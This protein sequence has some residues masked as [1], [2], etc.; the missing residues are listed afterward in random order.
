MLLCTLNLLAQNNCDCDDAKKSIEIYKKRYDITVKEDNVYLAIKLCNGG[1]GSVFASANYCNVELSFPNRQACNNWITQ[2]AGKYNGQNAGALTGSYCFQC[3]EC[4]NFGSSSSSSM[5]TSSSNNNSISSYNN[6]STS[7]SGGTLLETIGGNLYETITTLADAISLIGQEKQREQIEKRRNKIEKEIDEE[8]AHKEIEKQNKIEAKNLK[9]SSIYLTKSNRDGY[10]L[11][12]EIGLD[13]KPNPLNFEDY[14]T[15]ALW[16]K[17]F[18]DMSDEEFN[19]FIREY[20][21]FWKDYC[22]ADEL[23]LISDEIKKELIDLGIDFAKILI[24][25]EVETAA[26]IFA[27]PFG[28]LVINAAVQ[29]IIAGAS[30]CAKAINHGK[31]CTTVS[32]KILQS[33]AKSFISQI[34]TESKLTNIAMKITTEIVLSKN[35]SLSQVA[36]IG[37]NVGLKTWG[38]SVIDKYC[39]G[40]S[41]VLIPLIDFVDRATPNVELKNLKR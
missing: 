37:A 7:G 30:E 6:N 38:A 4:N 32:R 2:N 12:V 3:I 31:S 26:S 39:D 40:C 29:P 21:R 1:G 22:G 41:H 36:T 8:I 15:R 33:G 14:I 9:K 10:D 11:L 25:A 5:G 16:K 35:N 28:G 27:T 17:D 24:S 13:H 18:R 23:G 34:N 19:T 20:N